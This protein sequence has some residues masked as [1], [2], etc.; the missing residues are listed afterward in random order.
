MIPTDAP[1]P[2]GPSEKLNPLRHKGEC[3]CVTVVTIMI[4]PLLGKKVKTGRELIDGLE[5]SYTG[6]TFR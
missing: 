2:P 4:P 1:P 3:C 6:E 5:V